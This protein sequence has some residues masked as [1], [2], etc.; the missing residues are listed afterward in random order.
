MSEPVHAVAAVDSGTKCSDAQVYI[1]MH[2]S[3]AEK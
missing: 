1:S 2:A 3:R